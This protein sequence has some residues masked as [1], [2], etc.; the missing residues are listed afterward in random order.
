MARKPRAEK[1]DEKVVPIGGKKKGAAAPAAAA[2]LPAPKPAKLGGSNG[3]LEDDTVRRHCGAIQRAKADLDKAT[4]A[5]QQAWKRAKDDGC[6]AAAIRQGIKNLDKTVEELVAAHNDLMQVHRV[7]G[8]QLELG[9]ASVG[10]RDITPE[11]VIEDARIAGKQAASRGEFATANPHDRNVDA[12]RAWAEEY[13]K[14]QALMRADLG[15]GKTNAEKEAA[16]Q[17]SAEF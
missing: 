12:G 17:R 8:V 2:D 4:R 14:Q 15:L 11:S 9:L 10:G 1:P 5:H 16:R 3:G 7:L 6:N 13:D